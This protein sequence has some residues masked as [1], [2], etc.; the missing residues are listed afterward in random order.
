M[1]WFQLLEHAANGGALL[2]HLTLKATVLLLLSLAVVAALRRSSAALRHTLWAVC[3]LC[4]LLLPVFTIG[5]PAW[6]PEITKPLDSTLQSAPTKI[7]FARKTTSL[8]LR[9]T[10]I[11]YNNPEPVLSPG[12]WVLAILFVCWLV[13]M[14]AVTRKLIA[15][16]VVARRLSRRGTLVS[17]GELWDEFTQCAGSLNQGGSAP[18]KLPR[19]LLVE[20]EA[21]Q[22]PLTWGYRHPVVLMPSASQQ[23]TS[24]CRRA[25]LLHELS[26]IRRLDW[27]IQSLASLTCLLYWFHPLT[28]FASHRL[29]LESERA[30]DD[31]VLTTG[32][33]ATDYS[34]SLLE[35]V[36]FVG[37]NRTN[38][39][40]KK[41]S[42]MKFAV[43][44]SG[45][46]KIEI[47]LRSILDPKQSRSAV[48]K[49]LLAGIT[50]A[51]FAAIVPLA[52]AKEPA[53][54]DKP[55]LP[56][57][58]ITPPNEISVPIFN[59]T[60]GIEVVNSSPKPLVTGFKFNGNKAL[61]S[62][63]LQKLLVSKTG[64]PLD[65]KIV[66]DDREAL[67]RAY[68][69]KGI[70]LW[71]KEVVQ[72]EKG[73][74]TYTVQEDPTVADSKPETG[75]PTT[76]KGTAIRISGASLLYL[77]PRGYANYI[78]GEKTDTP[79]PPRTVVGPSTTYQTGTP[80]Y[81]MGEGPTVA[82]PRTIIEPS[83]I[84][85]RGYANYITGGEPA[86][87]RI[88]TLNENI[89]APPRIH[90][91]IVT[92]FKF[93]G[94]KAI[95]SDELQK[96]L[97]SK[98]EVLLVPENLTAD[99]RAI[100]KAYDDKGLTVQIR[101]AGQEKTGII[102]YVL[103]EGQVVTG[104]KFTGNTMLK[105]ED[106]QKVLVSKTGALFD[107]RQASADRE[108]IRKAYTDKG[109]HVVVTD[110]QQ[111]ETGNI[112]YDLHEFP[113]G[114]VSRINNTAPQANDEQ[115]LRVVKA[116]KFTGNTA[117]NSAELQKALISKA[118]V[119][120]N[121]P[122]VT[123]DV[124]AIQKLYTEKNFAVLVKLVQQDDAGVL[125]F[126]LLEAKLTQIKLTGLVKTDP[127]SVRKLITT[128]VN[129]IFDAAK[130]RRDLG[131][132]YATGLFEDATFK[133]DDD[134]KEGGVIATF[135]LKEK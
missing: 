68:A 38:A 120:L 103:Q 88:S 9:T 72:D 32:L 7:S 113:T 108:A 61:S 100:L 50:L 57:E 66:S 6:Q 18:T 51:S 58:N 35:I 89:A 106:L 52:A 81:I 119:P 46:S 84:H 12:Q 27:L 123:S 22:I 98:T 4:L 104:F 11:N 97:V 111:N 110:I 26:H 94:N 85:R 117:L 48:T 109:L 60:V 23:W 2:V 80:N 69:A 135:L 54:T 36:R 33:K 73:I 13:G 53:E 122:N 25:A 70:S 134:T 63:E 76:I 132:L 62:D 77:H 75:S 114:G 95:S 127:K 15:G 34:S 14:A 1:N 128:E 124:T 64:G 78:T 21:L 28:W 79:P 42:L 39:L 74:V 93:S 55:T 90:S 16:F 121:R 56:Q 92:G 115:P 118:G 83:F 99:L 65:A 96:V 43:P 49:K 37:A 71:L 47:R 41:D 20:D 19:L 102:S 129:E 112:S 67:Q 86:N 91:A 3:C 116:I 131:R 40:H 10:A 125:T 126:T 105:A 29:R 8:L 5:L 31:H 59:R 82:G 130:L 87:P 133:V 44:M 107:L 45:T 24:S 30:T 101:G 17:E